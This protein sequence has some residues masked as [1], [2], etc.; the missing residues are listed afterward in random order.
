M[1]TLWLRKKLTAIYRQY[2]QIQ[3]RK[4]KLFISFKSH[5][6]YQGFKINYNPALVKEIIW[7]LIGDKPFPDLPTC[8]CMHDATSMS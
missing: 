5:W 6:Y 7:S 4:Y 2:F 1:Q 3:I 8:T